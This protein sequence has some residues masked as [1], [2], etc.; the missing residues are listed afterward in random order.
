MDIDRRKVVPKLTGAFAVAW[1]GAGETRAC[2][3]EK[4]NVVIFFPYTLLEISEEREYN[5]LHPRVKTG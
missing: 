4:Q 3:Y 1:E 2:H 5:K